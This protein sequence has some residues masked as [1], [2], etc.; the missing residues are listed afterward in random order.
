MLSLYTSK[1][2]GP[3]MNEKEI[4]PKNAYT[5]KPIETLTLDNACYTYTYLQG[6]FLFL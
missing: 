1:A 2:I 3:G 6:K 5:L 4:L